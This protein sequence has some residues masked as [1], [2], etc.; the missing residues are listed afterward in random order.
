M[1]TPRHSPQRIAIVGV[2]GSGKTTLARQLS[3]HLGIPHVELDAF[4]WGPH[5]TESPRDVFR[6][7]VAQAL[8]GEAWVTDGNYGKARDIV[9]GHADTLVWLDYSLPLILW[10]LL[11]RSLRRVITRQELWHGNRESWRSQFLSRD[12]LFVWAWQTYPR[13]RR[14]YPQLFSQPEYAHLVLVHLR[15]PRATEEWLAGL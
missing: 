7:R 1:G 6:E 5:W 9:W 13:F 4:Y 8:S 2:T 15:T 14:T 12:S 3:Q 11:R 10:R